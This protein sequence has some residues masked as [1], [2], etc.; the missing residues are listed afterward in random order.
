MTGISF[1][2]SLIGIQALFEIGW[3]LAFSGVC[4]RWRAVLA[5][6]NEHSRF[7]A[8]IEPDL[9]VVSESNRV[10]I[11]TLQKPDICFGK[12]P[13]LA[14]F[15]RNRAPRR[16]DSKTAQ[17]KRKAIQKK[18]PSP[19]FEGT[20]AEPDRI[21]RGNILL[22]GGDLKFVER[23][24]GRAPKRWFQVSNC[25]ANPN[26]AIRSQTCATH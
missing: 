24:K 21:C 9:G 23:R 15:L 13:R 4:F 19:V 11:V 18:S 5:L 12:L 26:R 1:E 6:I 17:K 22:A 10:H 20:K 7:I 25:A 8:N 16:V 2:H 3:W 14:N